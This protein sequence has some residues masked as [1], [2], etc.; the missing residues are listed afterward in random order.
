M[1]NHHAMSIFLI[2]LSIP[3]ILWGMRMNRWHKTYLAD[4]L[5]RSQEGRDQLDGQ[6]LQYWTS[7][8]GRSASTLYRYRRLLRAE[9]TGLTLSNV[10]DNRPLADRAPDPEAYAVRVIAFVA[11]V[12]LVLASSI[13]SATASVAWTLGFLTVVFV[14]GL[15]AAKPLLTHPGDRREKVHARKH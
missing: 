1:Q 10:P 5:R 11:L 8:L 12:S 6:T 15:L 9:A 7:N 4:V 14:T 13:L 2:A 3:V